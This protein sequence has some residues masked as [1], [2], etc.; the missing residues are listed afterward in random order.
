MASVN[1]TPQYKIIYM[2][3]HNGLVLFRGITS[4]FFN[5]TGHIGVASLKKF[6]MHAA[7]VAFGDGYF[8]RTKIDT[9]STRA[10][11]VSQGMRMSLQLYSDIAHLSS[12]NLLVEVRAAAV[13][14]TSMTN[15]Y[16]L[17]CADT[18]IE[19]ARCVT[20]L[21]CT[22]VDSRRPTPLPKWFTE[23]YKSVTDTNL[24]ILK[25]GVKTSREF[26]HVPQDCFR[27]EI[28]TR[29]SDTDFNDHVNQSEYIQFCLESATGATRS[30]YYRHFTSDILWYPVL[31]SDIIHLGESRACE[32]LT[33]YTW[34]DKTNIQIIHFS[35]HNKS[36]SK[37][38]AVAT[39]KFDTGSLRPQAN[40]SL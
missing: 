11:L 24:D 26:R 17:S 2:S 31:E 21:V 34:Q 16:I 14:R 3:S 13:G 35:I 37:C 23:K 15:L 7:M 12:S 28:K 36:S 29:Y 19:L 40:S 6:F 25:D 38:V 4:S 10:F 27:I 18:K 39:I 33:I 30:G 20:T 32:M 1:E 5:R 8:D 22:S 9:D